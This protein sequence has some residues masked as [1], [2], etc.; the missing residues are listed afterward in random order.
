LAGP[1]KRIA[2]VM[3]ATVIAPGDLVDQLLDT[4]AHPQW[5]GR[6]FPFF[7]SEPTDQKHWETYAQILRREGRYEDNL[8]AATA[9]YEKHREAMDAGAVV[10]WPHRY[11]PGEISAIQHG[12][13]VKILD[14]ASFYAEYQNQPALDLQ[15]EGQYAAPDV[16][17]AKLNG[18]RRGEV[19]GWA[20]WLTMAIDVHDKLL[21]WGVGAFD[22][23]FHGAWV[24]YGT[25]PDQKRS[26]F[27]LREARPT[28]QSRTPGAGLDAAIHAGLLALLE[29]QLGREFVAEDGGRLRISICLIDE[30]YKPR[31]VASAIRASPHAGLVHPSRG[32]SVRAGNKP[33]GEYDTKPG[34]LVGDHWRQP[35]GKSRRAL[36]S[37][38]I[39]TNYWK[40]QLHAGLAAPLG[41]QRTLELFTHEARGR[42]ADHRMIADQ[43]AKAERY[44]MTTGY[45][46]TVQEWAELPSRADNHG[47]DVGVG[48][49]VGASIKGAIIPGTS[50]LRRRRRR[51][52]VRYHDT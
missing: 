18:H 14:A 36:R 7:Y 16:I 2:A 31:V 17:L 34:D 5:Q 8:H 35:A 27:F 39:D 46:R 50:I 28:L 41:D 43:I 3:P 38:W 24:D 32:I 12:Q 26:Y 6:R 37:V 13:N 48:L 52:R 47:F 15:T 42:K 11:E 19:P 9:H 25:W 33:F 1:D 40:T 22:R 10:A 44:A 4:E 21:Y 29:V 45:G 30:G 23:S 51:R 20:S 49:M